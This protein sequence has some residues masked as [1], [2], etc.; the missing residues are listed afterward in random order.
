MAITLDYGYANTGSCKSAITYLD[1]E[2]GILRY[3]GYPVKELAEKSRFV[4]VA[5]LLVH[6]KLPTEEEQVKFSELLNRQSMIHE[7]MRHFFYNYP[8]HA[9][10]MGILS[11]MVVALSSFYPEMS[12]E[13]NG[14]EQTSDEEIDIATTRLLAKIRT[15]AAFSYKKSVGEPFVYPRHD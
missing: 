14:S 11:A 6:G 1:G 15:I 7:D 4:E 12:Q 8:E 9:H 5:Y 13:Q 10:P 3:R 2:N